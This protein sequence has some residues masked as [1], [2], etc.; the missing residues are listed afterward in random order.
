MNNDEELD[1]MSLDFI[2]EAKKF[3]K[4]NKKQKAKTSYVYRRNNKAKKHQRKIKKKKKLKKKKN[5]DK[6]KTIESSLE[7]EITSENKGYKL[8]SKMGYKKGETLGKVNDKE[9]NE[10]NSDKLSEPIKINVKKSFAIKRKRGI[11][12]YEKTETIKRRRLNDLKEK[13]ISNTNLQEQY[14]QIQK[15]RYQM[16]K[17]LSQLRDIINTTKL[18]DEESNVEF[19]ELLCYKVSNDNNDTDSCDRSLNNKTC[20][21]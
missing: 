2:K 4:Q 1:Y 16:K 7:N 18:L 21:K 5:L 9:G 17:V 8:L 13:K 20:S 19:N 3:D 10:N 12:F 14:N 11:G 6:I 15:E